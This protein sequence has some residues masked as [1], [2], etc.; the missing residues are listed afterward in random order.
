MPCKI[1]HLLSLLDPDHLA[2]ADK[3]LLVQLL[4]LHPTAPPE[5]ATSMSNFSVFRFLLHQNFPP[6]IGVEVDLEACVETS[7][8]CAGR[9]LGVLV[10]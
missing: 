4:A 6:G 9:P 2:G 8:V 7:L 1:S 10:L 3:L 5:K